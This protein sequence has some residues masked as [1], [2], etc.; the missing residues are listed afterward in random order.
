MKQSL[1]VELLVVLLERGVAYGAMFE[2]EPDS[3]HQANE[4]KP[5]EN[6]VQSCSNLC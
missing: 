6:I 1:V 5:V 4:M 2:G 3:M